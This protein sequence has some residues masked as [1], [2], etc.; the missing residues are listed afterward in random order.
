MTFLYIL[1]GIVGAFIGLMIFMRILIYQK[2]SAMKGKPAPDLAG[3]PG[4]RIKK[5]KTAMFYFY[6][7][8]CGACK[9]MTPLVKDL[10][11]KNEGVFPVDISRDMEIARKF[12]VMATPTLVIVRE[13]MVAEIIIGPQPAARLEAL[14]S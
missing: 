5:G 4:K 12:S 7:P 11:K 3:K 8:Q 1:L 14:A 9:A 6:S 13:K 10:A 2:S